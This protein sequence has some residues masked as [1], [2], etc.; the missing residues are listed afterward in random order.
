M[1]TTHINAYSVLRVSLWKTRRSST[2]SATCAFVATDSTGTVSCGSAG[3]DG[4]SLGNAAGPRGA[5][6]RCARSSMGRLV[7]YLLIGS[8]WEVSESE[9]F[10]W[11]VD[12]AQ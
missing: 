1:P 12:V 10:G 5:S 3:G 4:V 7:E 11:P 2:S 9:S 8:D 6:P